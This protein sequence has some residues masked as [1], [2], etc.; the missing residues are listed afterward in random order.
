M[1]T[2]TR[3][4]KQSAI[5]EA[6]PIY[7]GWVVWF[8]ATIG[9][10][11]TSP[12]QS[13]TVGL[14]FDYF[15]EDFGLSRTAVSTLYSVGTFAASLSLTFVGRLIDRFGNRRMG[16]V[17]AALFAVALV[18]MS[19]VTGPLSLLIGFIALRG[20]GQ[21]S[22]SLVNTTVIAEWFKRLRGRIMSASVV[23]FAL[24]QAVYVPWVQRMLEVRDWREVW[25]ILGIGMAA[26]VIPLTWLFMRDRPEDYGLIPD[27]DNHKGKIKAVDDTPDAAW[28]L[29]EALRTAIFWVFL[30]GRI[31]SPAWG[32]GMIIHQVSIFEGLGWTA[33]TAAETYALITLIMAGTAIIFGYLV[34]RIPPGWVLAIQM[35]ALITSMVMATM[36]S[37]QILLYV[38]AIGFG[39]VMGGGGIF[40]NSVWVNVYGR[41]HQGSIRGF[42]TMSLVAGTALG[43]IIFGVSYD[44]LGGYTPVL[45]LGV[46]L[47]LVSLVLAI[48]VPLPEKPKRKNDEL[49]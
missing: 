24:F 15:I 11:F 20:L 40:D 13:F 48:V 34:D 21:G 17:I 27:G 12:A 4:L 31:I 16:V 14:F 23:G 25:V 33:R 28:T 32:T 36:M 44:Y 45:W 38:Y 9:W 1:T 29:S 35:F 19:Y 2:T 49:V 43:P 8:V 26:I 42:I 10:I 30:L 46:A 47:S 41:T 22:Q 18:M 37:T 3:P 7:Y 5:V 39:F 6:S